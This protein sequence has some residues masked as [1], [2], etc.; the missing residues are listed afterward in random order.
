M[1]DSSSLTTVSSVSPPP[2]SSRVEVSKPIPIVREPVSRRSIAPEHPEP[3]LR[4][5]RVN[6]VLNVLI[7]AVALLLLSPL[8]LV[9]GA[10]VRMSSPGPIFYTQARVG[11]N[12]RR[13]KRSDEPNYDR[14]SRD[15]GGRPF[16]IYKFRTMR[17][18][19]EKPNR[20]VWATNHDPRVT[21]IGRI[22]RTYRVD[23]LPQL[24]NV[25]RGEMNIVGPRPERPSIFSRLCDDIEEYPLRQRAKPGITGWA[26]VNRSYDT[27]LDDVRAKVQYDLEYLRR[28]GVAEDLRIMARTL[29]VMLFRKGGW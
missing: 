17:S 24:I 10:L 19:A 14:R 6:R 12:R 11:I 9:I 7:A 16:L 21:P 22:M 28:Q 18:G 4:S 26:Q 20:P 8:M 2:T 13:E 23:E 25:I 27:T 3:R 5:E 1:I 29:P 15:L